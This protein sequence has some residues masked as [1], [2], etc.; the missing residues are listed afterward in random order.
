MI[1]KD[2]IASDASMWTGTWSGCDPSTT[3]PRM[4]I[5]TVGIAGLAIRHMTQSVHEANTSVKPT[6]L[7]FVSPSG[8]VMRYV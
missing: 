3:G 2:R 4:P 1:A 5:I 8:L 6:G 7:R